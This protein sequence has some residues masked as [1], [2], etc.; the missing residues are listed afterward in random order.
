MNETTAKLGE[1]TGLKSLVGHNR[2]YLNRMLHWKLTGFWP[3]FFGPK[4]GREGC[5][6]PADTQR[7]FDDPHLPGDPKRGVRAV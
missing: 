4:P 2:D 6:I 5:E 3:R 7:L 1:L